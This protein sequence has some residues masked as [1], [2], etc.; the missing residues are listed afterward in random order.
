MCIYVS[1]HGIVIIEIYHHNKQVYTLYTAVA[2]FSYIL[3]KCEKTREL[4]DKCYVLQ[5]TPIIYMQPYTPR[6]P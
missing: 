6:Q 4:K 3:P 2:S 5:C 1:M